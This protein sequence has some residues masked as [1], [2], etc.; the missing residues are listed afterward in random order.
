MNC[1]KWFK[2]VACVIVCNS[3]NE[4]FL[5]KRPKG[6]KE[7]GKWG[8]SGGVGDFGVSQSREDFALRELLYDLNIKIDPVKLF[9]FK[10]IVYGDRKFLQIE[11]I[12][13]YEEDGPISV[14]GRRRV[15]VEGQWFS[16][17]EIKKMYK[18][19]EIAFDNFEI[20]IEFLK[21]RDRLGS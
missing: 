12:F 8:I 11:D 9:F 16:A 1:P 21:T 3:Q 14:S 20:I 2:C 17:G 18:R 13:Y 4:I 5:G 6:V 7:Q 10:T 15:P 19:G